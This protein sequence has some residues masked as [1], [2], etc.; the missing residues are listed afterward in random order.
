MRGGDSNQPLNSP[1]HTL[2]P[3]LGTGCN[4]LP[5][6]GSTEELK[7]LDVHR[8]AGVPDPFRECSSCWVKSVFLLFILCAPS[9]FFLSCHLFS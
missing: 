7:V 3:N 8:R 9:L 6:C 5:G 4:G 2:F 1:E